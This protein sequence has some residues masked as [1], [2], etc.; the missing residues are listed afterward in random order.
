MPKPDN[1]VT[2]KEKCRPILLI[3]NTDTKIQNK[4]LANKIQ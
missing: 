1:D 2:K 3:M 4:I